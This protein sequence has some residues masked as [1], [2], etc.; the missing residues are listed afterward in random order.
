MAIGVLQD[1]LIWLPS[2]TEKEGCFT[3]TMVFDCLD[4]GLRF[5]LGPFTMMNCMNKATARQDIDKGPPIPSIVPL[6][7]VVAEPGFFLRYTTKIH[8]FDIG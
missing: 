6:A 7:F 2:I 3:V 4:K 5:F 1:L 8:Q